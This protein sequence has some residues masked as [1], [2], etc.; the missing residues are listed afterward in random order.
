MSRGIW[1]VEGQLGGSREVGPVV[2]L[3]KTLEGMLSITFVTENN[4]ALKV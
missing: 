1:V 3:V 2:Y 4:L